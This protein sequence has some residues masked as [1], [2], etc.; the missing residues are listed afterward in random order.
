MSTTD[1]MAELV[2]LWALISEVQLTDQ[3]DVIIWKWTQTGNYT[4]KSAYLAQLAGSYCTFDSMAIWKAKTEGKQ[5]FFAW[6]L[7]QQKILTADKLMARNW[8]CNP[9][10]VLCDQELETANHLCLQCVFAQEVW[11][12]V[13]G[14]TDGLI[15]PPDRQANLELWWNEALS[16]TSGKEKIKK[17][18]IMIYTAWNIW[19]ER[20]RRVFAKK[21]TRPRRILQL[22][23]GDLAPRASACADTQGLL[24]N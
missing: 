17:A 15:H 3:E 10:C 7:V 6:L 1:E 4:A 14:W 8:P 21:T 9:N 19:K 11:L 24:V 18:S 20:N 22:I 16:A 13:A 5:R 2:S 23:K 12:L